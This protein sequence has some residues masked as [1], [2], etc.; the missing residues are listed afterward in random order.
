[1]LKTDRQRLALRMGAAS[2]CRRDGE[3][4][5]QKGQMR[6]EIGGSL[7]FVRADHR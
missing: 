6:C 5:M 2:F 4:D 3:E 7:E 1:M